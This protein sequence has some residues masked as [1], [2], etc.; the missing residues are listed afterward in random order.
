[1]WHLAQKSKKRVVVSMGQVEA[2]VMENPVGVPVVVV[3]AVL[4]DVA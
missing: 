2:A 4:P 1:M 3:D